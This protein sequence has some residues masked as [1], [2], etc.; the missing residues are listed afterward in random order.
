MLSTPSHVFDEFQ[1]KKRRRHRGRASH[2]VSNSSAPAPARP[3]DAPGHAATSGGFHQLAF[4]QTKNL[5]GVLDRYTQDP[6]PMPGAGSFSS[7]A[8]RISDGCS[9]PAS[10]LRRRRATLPAEDVSEVRELHETTNEVS[11]GGIGNLSSL[12]ARSL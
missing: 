9:T 1:Q 3:V 5:F 8:R 7:G 11:P 6:G 10:S 4:T 12:M 2:S